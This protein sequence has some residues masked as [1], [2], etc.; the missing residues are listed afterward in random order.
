[1][2]ASLKLPGGGAQAGA[3]RPGRGAVVCI[4]FM[5]AGKSTAAR[6]L[7]EA[8]GSTPIG[9]GALG[10]AVAIIA[11]FVDKIID[12][13]QWGTVGNLIFGWHIGQQHTWVWWLAEAFKWISVALTFSRAPVASMS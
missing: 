11:I 9:D 12:K 10:L 3:N 4:G 13:N 8:L 2:A 1:M 6:S 5:G 7:A